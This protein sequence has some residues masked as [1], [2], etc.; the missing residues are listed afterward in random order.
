MGYE[1]DP[2]RFQ[3][4][5]NYGYGRS[6]KDVA[7]A[8]QTAKLTSLRSMLQAEYGSGTPEDLARIASLAKSSGASMADIGA[9]LGF[10]ESDIRKIFEG[11]GI[12]AFDV[13][14]NYV[15]RDMLAQI[16]EGEAVVPKAYNPWANGQAMQGGDPELLAEIRAMRAELA[17]LRAAASA[18]ANNTAAMPQ[19][20]D[21]FDTVTNGGN[22]M[23]AK[24]LA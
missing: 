19:M 8:D 21:Q 14:T 16:H 20:A 15:P 4:E 11:A 24:A 7:D 23:R 12:P 13:G 10:W 22:A 9:A 17:A 6:F 18:T 5:F 1:K 2:V 3:E